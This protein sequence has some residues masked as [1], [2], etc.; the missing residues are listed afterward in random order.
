MLSGARR[1]LAMILCGALA[2]TSAVA[3][4]LASEAPPAQAT[5]LP[6]A[7]VDCYS[8]TFDG[9][10]NNNR[11][12]ATDD[13]Y[14][15]DA[16]AGQF[17]PGPLYTSLTGFGNGEGVLGNDYVLSGFTDER[18]ELTRTNNR[19]VLW[20][21]PDHAKS[22]TLN[23][24]GT[25]T[26]VPKDGYYGADSFQYV[27]AGPA[28]GSP[29]SNVATVRI[30]AVDQMRSQNDR[31]VAYKDTP[32]EVGKIV[33]GF[34]CGVLDNDL[35]TDRNS[36]VAAV[37]PQLA[38]FIPESVVGSFTS[39]AT[40]AGGTL[41]S[42]GANGSFVYTPPPG[43]TGEDS[44]VYR[45]QRLV[46]GGTQPAFGPEGTT[47]A[48]VFITVAEPPAP[49]VPAGAA[50][51]LDVVEDTPLTFQAGDLL[52]NDP[53]G[54]YVTY[55]GGAQFDG[56]VTVRTRHGTLETAWVGFIPGVP[57]NLIARTMTYTPDPDFTGVDRFTYFV[58]NN[59]IDGPSTEVEVFID[60]SPVVDVPVAA[61]DAATIDEDTSITI[62][63]AAND[64]DGDG[65]LVPSTVR[66]DPCT[67]NLCAPVGWD[68]FLNGEWTVNGDGTVTYE[69]A[70][71]FVG[72]AIFL[73]EISDA[74]GNP[75][76][77]RVTVTVLSNDAM[78]DEYSAVEDELLTV[79]APGVLEN[80]DP[81]ARDDEAVL[82]R[83][84]ERGIVE[85]AADGSFTYQPGP[86]FAGADSFDYT[87][88][89]DTATVT[90]AVAG[91]NDSPTVRFNAYCDSSIPLFP[92]LGDL[93]DRDL[94]EGETAVLRGSI[95]DV[96][97]NGG[98][99]SIDWGD[100][101]ITAGTY[102][103]SADDCPFDYFPTYSTGIC[104]PLESCAG[105][106][107]FRFEHR[108]ADDPSG[109][110]SYFPITMTLTEGDGTAGGG[111]T[112]ARVENAAPALTL[113]SSCGVDDLCI[114]NFS[115]LSGEP[116]DQLRIGGRI[117]D[118]G[119]DDG[120]I[121]IDWGD[122]SEP[123]VIP[124]GCGDVTAICPT[125]AEQPLGCAFSV[126]A[127]ASCGYFAAT[128]VFA[129]GG[130]Y[131]ATVSV[132]DG[133]GTPVE[134]TVS[135][136]VVVINA[137]PIAQDAS[138]STLEDAP[139]V[140]DLADLVTDE[141]T[142]DGSLVFEI[143]EQPGAGAVVLDGSIV[144]YTPDPDTNGVD[145][146]GY[147][148]VDRGDPADCATPG[149]D[150][151]APL[152]ATAVIDVTVDAVNDA[153][154]FVAGVDVD[155]VADGVAVVLPGWATDI[156][157][158]PANESTQSVEFVI[159]TD[160][161]AL[162]AD[163]GFPTIAVDGTLTFTPIADGV[164]TLRITAIDDGLGV[165]PDVRRSEPQTVVVTIVPPNLAPVITAP[166][167]VTGVW[168]DTLA[169]EL[170]ASDPES[171]VDGVSLEV[172][173]LPAGLEVTGSAVGLLIAG[174][175]DA[176]P[177]AY[178]VAISAC[179]AQGACSQTILIIEVLP[180]SASVRLSSSTPTS[181]TAD[182][183]G[184]AGPIDI[185][186]RITED[187]DRSW[188]DLSQ[189]S[190]AD[191]SVT[192]RSEATGVEA[193]C[194]PTITRVSS[195]RGNAAG[196]L[197]VACRAA[198]GLPVGVYDL[199][200][201]IGGRLAGSASAVLTVAGGA[202][203]GDAQSGEGAVSL[204]GGTRGEFA[205]EAA[206]AGKRS[207]TGAWSF[208]ERASDGQVVRTIEAT[209]ITSIAVTG[210][211][212][213]RTLEIV[214]KAEVDGVG[215]YEVRVTARDRAGAPDEYGHQ[216]SSG[217]RPVDPAW[218]VSLRALIAGSVTIR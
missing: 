14:D 147:R 80:D 116:G 4:S 136:Q 76:Y 52:A 118:P 85:L 35:L 213:D 164:A 112:S 70:E 71:D 5:H 73:Y 60:V 66:K 89:G 184:L 137:A 218:S 193:T 156:S 178:D 122:G 74:L 102:P 61:D 163:D 203:A 196:S 107:F 28:V 158:G 172:A 140:V 169:V 56:Q 30:L 29:C 93:D 67:V 194:D 21:P 207:A 152:A 65:D 110:S 133:D 103:C 161:G 135:L 90:I 125:P 2:A 181:V 50:D 104:I 157:A 58:A 117:L 170:S 11:V 175:L 23:D 190:S 51:L 63:V 141:E 81:A 130:T 26:Y 115:V 39:I 55:I 209:S 46:V 179:D 87:A 153:P 43:F 62:A 148:V 68:L 185:G 143:V 139:A 142:P 17:S 154:S 134:S 105:P 84:A 47:H 188:A 183:T 27:Y 44:F 48:E 59:P 182:A 15:R 98:S 113:G 166:T 94:V 40:R 111:S 37:A 132:D 191:V 88:G 215:G 31:Y 42:V 45:A 120:T 159:E 174:V 146:F 72:E 216:I 187:S 162:F 180:E 208:I 119:A 77:A 41:S 33:C 198:S 78:D 64:R 127:S 20:S 131:S 124:W 165:A 186:A 217:K 108:Y 177:G 18:I 69:P 38:W 144:T 19:A 82:T 32:L 101:T 129:T 91:V 53:N 126:F 75:D 49:D 145:S 54:S 197:E 138:I 151:A 83:S 202:A 128:H 12:G 149:D 9:W 1:S 79:E 167:S 36:Q 214:A 106:L 7:S 155:A 96:E 57:F 206:V 200:V 171:G 204:P 160:D 99:Y 201:S 25:F 13:V 97:S 195:A 123:S 95:S 34:W 24:N 150:C 176:E 212:G 8:G 6:S 210:V 189:V 211:E 92:C 3:L 16:L 173:G 168:S 10:T 100:G 114:G 86:D 205:F 121:T 22:F 109:Q 192:L 199:E